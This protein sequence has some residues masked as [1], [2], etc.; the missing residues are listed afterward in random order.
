MHTKNVAAL[1]VVVAVIVAAIAYLDMERVVPV[2]GDVP[3]D[4]I[5]SLDTTSE[6]EPAKEISSPDDFINTDGKPVTIG[7]LIGKKVVLLDIWTYS[8]INCQRT[9]PYLNSWHEKYAGKGLVIIGLHTPEFEFEKKYENVL[10]AV[11]K[12]GI[13]YPVVLDNDYS[14]WRAYRNQYW[15]RKYLID[16]KGN[17]VYDHI[18]EGAYEET[19]RRIQAALKDRMTVL[20]EKGTVDVGVTEEKALIRPQSPETYFGSARNDNLGNGKANESGTQTLSIPE[21]KLLNLLYLGGTWTIEPEFAVNASS[22]VIEF[23]YKAKEVYFV[24]SSATGQRVK[25]YNDGVLQKGDG[26]VDCREKGYCGGE[27]V[28]ADGTVYI[29]EDRLYKLIQ[30]ERVEEHV[31]KIEIESSGL[32]AFTFTFG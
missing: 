23:R 1:V 11:S 26:P 4:S 8:C 24:A 25:I 13:K 3:T 9:I 22:A 18:G 28:Q 29:Q 32:K 27:D 15:P 14:T 6:F 30:N 5:A 17:V 12:F 10:A 20:G 31:L 2:S 19:E 7:E 21:T 16:I